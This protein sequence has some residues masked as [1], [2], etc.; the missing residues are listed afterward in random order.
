MDVKKNGRFQ[1]LVACSPLAKKGKMD[2]EV[3]KDEK[4]RKGKESK[5]PEVLKSVF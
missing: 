3:K 2:K 1:F 4:C 5:Q